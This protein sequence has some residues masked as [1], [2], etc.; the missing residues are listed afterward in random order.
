MNESSAVRQIL[1][2]VVD[3]ADKRPP[4]FG[5]ILSHPFVLL[6]QGDIGSQKDLAEARHPVIV[7]GREHQRVDVQ[8]A[9]HILNGDLAVDSSNTSTS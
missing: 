8:I 1:N 4:S 5:S 7:A 9:Q 2:D 3:A 6:F